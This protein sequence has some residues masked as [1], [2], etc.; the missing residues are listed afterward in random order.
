MV[1]DPIFHENAPIFGK[2]SDFYYFQKA[3]F[4]TVFWG[5]GGQIKIPRQVL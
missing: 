2:N 5:S 4:F 1:F 3:T